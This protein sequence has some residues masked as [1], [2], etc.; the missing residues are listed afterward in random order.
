M[1]DSI[2]SHILGLAPWVAL[3]VVFAMPALESSAFVGF[4]FPGEIAL[5]LGGVLA[6]QGKV[7]LAA[8]LVAAIAGCVVGDSVGYAVGRRFGRRVLE[9]TIGRFVNHDHFDRAE[10]Y[11]AERGGKAVFFGRFTAALRVLVPGLAGMSGMRYRTF[12]AFNVASAVAWGTMSVLFGYLGGNSWQH[13]QSVASH[14]VLVSLA[15]VALLAI[16]GHFI[17]RG[18][19]ARARRA[20]TDD[21]PRQGVHIA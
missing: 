11:L 12:V 8:V 2:A 21:E 16:G 1:M 4:V 3:L 19:R 18:R 5:V 9:G 20:S 14:I 13:V 10:K 15:I 7:S 17:R 6:S